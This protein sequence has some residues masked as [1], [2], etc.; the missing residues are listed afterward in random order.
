MKYIFIFPLLLSY[1]VFILRGGLVTRVLTGGNTKYI[2]S[3]Q[4]LEVGVVCSTNSSLYDKV[5]VAAPH[6]D[7]QPPSQDCRLQINTQNTNQSEKDIRC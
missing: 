4:S 1:Q 2:F 5:T 6:T 7:W 3:L